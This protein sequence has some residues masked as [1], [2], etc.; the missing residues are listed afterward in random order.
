MSN[1]TALNV[2]DYFLGCL[3]EE[4]GDLMS[5]LK[6]QKLLYYAQGSSLAIH[7]KPL[8]KEK[9]M[10]WEHGPV[11]VEVYDKYKDSGSNAL[12]I[13]KDIDFKQFGNEIRDLLDEVYNVYGQFS[14]WMLRNMT[15]DEIPWKNTPRDSEITHQS[16]K[17]YF[18]TQL[19]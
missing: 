19:I 1:L 10:A 12:P 17:D 6:L 15:H 13:P 14:A 16:L 3:D 4:N 11:V 18:K 9:I 2:S 5:H 8:F 7:D